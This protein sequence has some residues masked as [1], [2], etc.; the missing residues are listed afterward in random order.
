MRS[1]MFIES[2]ESKVRTL[3]DITRHS[4]R[5]KCTHGERLGLRICV[6]L[7]TSEQD[8]EILVAEIL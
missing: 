5:V 6:V 7:G 8:A 3:R 1:S 2:N 4:K